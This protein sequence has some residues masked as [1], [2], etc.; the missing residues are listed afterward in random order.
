MVRIGVHPVGHALVVYIEDTADSAQA[1]AVQV[2]T[3]CLQADFLI[4]PVRLGGR[5]IAMAAQF[6][7]VT[8]AAGSS[9]AVF[10]LALFSP[11]IWTEGHGLQ[12]R[13]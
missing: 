13:Q 8:L 4:V 2:K 5:R 6:A 11:A 7:P 1:N 12:N 9:T 10:Y 3:K